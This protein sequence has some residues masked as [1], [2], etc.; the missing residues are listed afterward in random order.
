V[1]QS[2][3]HAF[4]SGDTIGARS[5]VRDDF[6][7]RAPLVDTGGTKDDFF[8]AADAKTRSIGGFHV[9][10]QWH[11]GNDVSTVYEID[12]RTLAGAATML[13]HEWHTVTHGQLASSIMIFDTSAPAAQLLH[14]ALMSADN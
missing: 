8:V 12:V 14:D 13:L 9:L 3:L 7:F 1:V 11:D 5:M 10:R 6:S 2:F 4:L